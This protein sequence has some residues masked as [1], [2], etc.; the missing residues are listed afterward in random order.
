MRDVTPAAR[1][2]EGTAPVHSG[3]W[4]EVGGVKCEEGKEEERDE[5]S[6]LASIC[7]TWCHI[8]RNRS[9]NS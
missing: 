9:Q 5:E 7:G 2:G 8:M 1:K 3:R 6:N 4:L